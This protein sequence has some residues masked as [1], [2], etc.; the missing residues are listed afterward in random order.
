MRSLRG[1]P[2][3][4]LA[5]AASKAGTLV[6][7]LPW[8]ERFRGALVVV[9]YGGNAM[10][11]DDAQGGLRPGHRL[12]AVCRAAAGRRPWRRPADRVDAEAAGADQ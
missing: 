3:D 10:I 11:D 12:P 4:A 5:T 9:K 2:A 1:E 7:A 8:L 6:E